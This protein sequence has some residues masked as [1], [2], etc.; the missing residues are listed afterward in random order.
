MN[1]SSAW[2]KRHYPGS[3]VT[4][5]LIIPPHTLASD[6]AL[7]EEVLIMTKK[8]LEQL[9]KNIRAF[10]SEFRAADL[11]DLSEKKIHDHRIAH[12]LTVDDL[13]Q[14]GRKPLAYKRA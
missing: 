3:A 13:L 5:I 8:Y 4:R 7:N 12:K 9:T 6:A 11:Q 14:Y 10:F 1:R 2:F